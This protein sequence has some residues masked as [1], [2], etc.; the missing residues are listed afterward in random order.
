MPERAK[1]RIQMN[2]ARFVG[3]FMLS[4]ILVFLTA[5][6][7]GNQSTST[8]NNTTVVKGISFAPRI[9]IATGGTD[10]GSVVL[11]D[12]NGDGKLD[13]AVS[14]FVSNTISV[15]LNNGNGTFSSPVVT[16]IQTLG[17]NNLGPIVSGDFNEDGKMD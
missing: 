14:N 15:F 3:T 4:V 2:G 13:I 6:S 1:E 8:G 11:E 17:A 10:S 5:C 9:D 16:T 12:F 7:S